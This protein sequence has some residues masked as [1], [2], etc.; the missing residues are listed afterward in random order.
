M[1]LS[2]N[3]AR[4]QARALWPSWL[5]TEAPRQALQILETLLAALQPRRI[6]AFYPMNDEYD[7][8]P[9]LPANAQILAPRAVS[10]L[11]EFRV[12]R[13]PGEAALPALRDQSGAPGASD[14]ATLL[15]QGAPIDIALLPALAAAAD[16]AR[17][18]RG[19]GYY[20][21]SQHLLGE[22]LRLALLPAAL[23]RLP[24]AG[25]EHDLQLDLAICENGACCYTAA[26]RLALADRAARVE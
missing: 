17:L 14:A 6:A 22:A 24:F 15:P 18:G 21:R 8:W 3:Q 12:V 4:Q 13:W 1:N 9:A 11:L 5:P 16:G 25:E 26:G 20:D 19:A 23:C 2:K 7:P 10:G